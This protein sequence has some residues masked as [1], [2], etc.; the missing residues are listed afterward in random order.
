MQEAHFAWF[1]AETLATYWSEHFNVEKALFLN[2]N[3][4]NNTYFIII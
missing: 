2:E 3:Y 4:S 1:E